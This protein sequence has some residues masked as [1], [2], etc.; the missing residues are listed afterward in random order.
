MI[1]LDPDKHGKQLT[2]EAA[3]GRL[4]RVPRATSTQ[5]RRVFADT[6]AVTVIARWR[7]LARVV[8]GEASG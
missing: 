6:A 1:W 5:D 3:L 7:P 2:G 8:L 4:L